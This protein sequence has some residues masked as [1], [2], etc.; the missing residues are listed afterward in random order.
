MYRRENRKYL[1]A[2]AF[3]RTYTNIVHMPIVKILA[4]AYKP[5]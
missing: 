3:L 5:R 2:N 1:N 4:L